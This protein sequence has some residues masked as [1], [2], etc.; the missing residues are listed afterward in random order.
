MSNSTLFIII[1]VL[2]V[3]ELLI[4]VLGYLAVTLLK[5]RALLQRFILYSVITLNSLRAVNSLL[6][7]IL[8]S[9]AQENNLK[10]AH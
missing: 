6:S 3:R 5:L 7:D 4:N 10:T 2:T 8:I 1:Y 9:Q